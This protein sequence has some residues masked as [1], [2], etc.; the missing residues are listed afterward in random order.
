MGLYSRYVVPHLVNLARQDKA[1]TA[2]RARYVPLAGGK[3]LEVGA[4]SALNIPFYGPE[5]DRLVALEPS[6]QLWELGRKRLAAAR[7]PVE[8]VQAS[9]ESIPAPDGAYDTVVMTWT[10]CS[11]GRPERALAEIARILKPAGRLIFI[12]HGRSPESHIT[13][14]QDRLNPVWRPLAGGCNMNRP[15][16]RLIGSTGLT[17]KQM[18][19]GYTP[20][21]KILS[22]LYKGVAEPSRGKAP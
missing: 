15:I 21:P 11:I 7:F 12:E 1:A 14:W 18:D 2:E 20:G 4:G 17:I 19:T 13:A 6:R 22:Y 16:D 5:V 8:F 3:V 9:A 10:L